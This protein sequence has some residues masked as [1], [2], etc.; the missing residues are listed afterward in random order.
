MYTRTYV[1]VYIH[2]YICMYVFAY[3]WCPSIWLQT[4]VLLLGRVESVLYFCYLHYSTVRTYVPHCVSTY[5]R[6]TYA[7]V[8]LNNCIMYMDVHRQCPH[9]RGAPYWECALGRRSTVSSLLTFYL[10]EVY[11][12]IHTYIH[13]CTYECVVVGGSAGVY[14]C[15][16]THMY[17]CVVVGG[18][19]GV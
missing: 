17:E 19:A 3:R 11:M 12:Y 10:V 1:Y 4:Y 18:S 2:M 6:I 8:W 14:M 5:I 15:L 16:H 9:W 13:R 7:H